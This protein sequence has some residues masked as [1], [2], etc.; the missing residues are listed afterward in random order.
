MLRIIATTD[1]TNLGSG[2][3]RLTVAIEETDMLLKSRYVSGSISWGD[4][5]EDQVI[6]KQAII[7]GT[8]TPTITYSKNFLPGKYVVK[9]TAQNYRAPTPDTDLVVFFIDASTE[10]FVAP[11]ASVSKI[12]GLIMPRQAGFPNEEQWNF[13]IGRDLET[14]VSS[15][16]LLLSVNKGE[17][18]MDPEFGTNLRR[19]VFEPS[20]TGGTIESM[21]QQEILL[22]VEKYAPSVTLQSISMSR[23]NGGSTINVD[24]RFLAK[25]RQQSF[26]VNLTFE[27]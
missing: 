17:R 15:L 22:A 21:V 1:D 19:I 11:A 4:G 25:P 18:L 26:R 7:F 24:I 5:S 13:N 23:L 16:T 9:V 14:T 2:L 6:E 3:L 27:R 12:V 20:D 10:T 8:A